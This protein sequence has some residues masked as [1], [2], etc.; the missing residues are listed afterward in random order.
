MTNYLSKLLKE[1]ML[2]NFFLFYRH[3]IVEGIWRSMTLTS[4]DGNTDKTIEAAINM[5]MMNDSS[6]RWRDGCPSPHCN[7]GCPEVIVLTALS[8]LWNTQY[9]FAVVLSVFSLS[10]VCFTVVAILTVYRCYLKKAQNRFMEDLA[11]DPYKDE[12]LDVS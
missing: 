6:I 2:L 11:C 3:K 12:I 10:I 7:P 5:W 9:L 1:L 4:H 8:T